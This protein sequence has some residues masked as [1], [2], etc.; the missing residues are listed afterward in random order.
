MPNNSTVK[1]QRQSLR[2]IHYAIL[3]SDTEEGAV[4]ESPQPLVGAISAS[5]SPRPAGRSSGQMTAYSTSRL[6]W[7]TS[8]WSWSLPRCP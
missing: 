1:A 5:I 4:Y 8:P 7:A 3:T 2:N 6:S